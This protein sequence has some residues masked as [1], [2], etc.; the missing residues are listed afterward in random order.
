MDMLQ[1]AS[2]WR[3]SESSDVA[4][5]GEPCTAWT[6]GEQ[7]VQQGDCLKLLATLPSDSI[8]VVVTSPPY[9]IGIAY[10][11]Y[12]DRRPRGEYLD[13][14]AKIGVELA[15]VLMPN[16]SFF[17]NVGGT[18]SDPWI[19]MD[20]AGAF[21]DLFVLQN[22]IVWVKSVSLGDDTAGHFKPITS[23]R[24]LNNNHEA[25]FHFTKTG[26]VEVDRLAIG[27]PYKDKSNIARWKHAKAD[28]RC[29]GNTWFIPYETVRSKVQKFDHPAGFPVGLPDRCIRLHG[30]AN[31]LVL[32]PFL[33]AGTTLV[34]A[35]RLECEGIGFELD[36]DYARAAVARL[37]DERR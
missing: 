1:E 17:L 24:F 21:R 20:V 25:V 30:V 18:G 6:V 22:H 32:D 31:A 28:K 34:A 26:K 13:W 29:A 4:V 12:A 10:N 33:G 11:S 16:G 19:T 35:E 8:D 15:R 37:R 27:V 9:N 23:K 36:P 3:D 14:L 7:T 2:L 5:H